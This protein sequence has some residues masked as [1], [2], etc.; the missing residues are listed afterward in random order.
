[1]LVHGIGMG[2]QYF[3]L[4]RDELLRTFNVVAIDLPGFGD[5]PEPANR[6]TMPQCAELLAGAIDDMHVA[7]VIAIG[8]SMGTQVVAELAA[9]HQELV[10]RVVL[11]APTVNSAERSKRRQTW[12]LVQDLMND[13]PVVGVVGAKMYVETG[14]RWFLKQFEAMLDHRIEDVL[15]RI[16]QP[17]LVIRGTED[18]VSTGPWVREVTALLPHGELREAEGKGHEAMITGAEPVS[19]LVQDFA[20]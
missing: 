17:T 16:Q 13:P 19:K 4:L 20:G 9:N 11:I 5:S 15:P 10:D 14:P 7:P 8:H 3:G 2:Q 1:M 6:L 12:R 18:L